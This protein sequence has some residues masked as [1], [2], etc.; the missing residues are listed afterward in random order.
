MPRVICTRV[1]ASDATNVGF[2]FVFWLTLK[3]NPCLNVLLVVD[4]NEGMSSQF[5]NIHDAFF[6][7]SLSDPRLAGQF[8]REHLPPDVVGQ[9]G[10]ERAGSAAS[11]SILVPPCISR[12]GAVG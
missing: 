7:Q 6:R 12:F 4:Q 11:V 8:L 2:L 1:F 5:A 3:A 9:L 10:P